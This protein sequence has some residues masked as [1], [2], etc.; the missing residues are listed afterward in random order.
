MAKRVDVGQAKKRPNFLKRNLL[1]ALYSFAVS[2]SKAAPTD[3]TLRIPR[4]LRKS[5]YIASAALFPASAHEVC[6]HEM[7]WI[8]RIVAGDCWN[9]S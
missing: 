5:F 7:P 8:P 2:V 1:R 6:A 9:G 4:T 3:A